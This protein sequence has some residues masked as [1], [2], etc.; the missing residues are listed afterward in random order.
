MDL[1][2]TGMLLDA[3]HLAIYQRTMGYEA[4]TGLADFP[5][6]RIVEMHVAGAS[7]FEVDGLS[8]VED[9]HTVEVLPE[10]W[11]IV[12]AVGGAATELRAVVFECERNPMEQCLP[13]FKKYI[14]YSTALPSA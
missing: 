1:A 9:D 7:E 14:G 8:M 4:T 12:T 10:T 2:D 5:M 3:A 11:E 6:D 13:G